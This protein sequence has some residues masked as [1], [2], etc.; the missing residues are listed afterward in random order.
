MLRLWCVLSLTLLCAELA[1]PQV[2][3]RSPSPGSTVLRVRVTDSSGT[4]IAGA[5]VSVVHGLNVVVAKGTTDSAGL[6][7]LAMTSDSAAYQVVVRKIGYLRADRFVPAS[8]RDTVSLDLVLA[9]NIQSLEAVRVA[10]T[11]SAAQKAYHIDAEEIAQ[12]DQLLRTAVDVI[13]KLRP[14]MIWGRAGPPTPHGNGRVC[15]RLSSVFVNGR[16][17]VDAPAEAW[18]QAESR[19]PRRAGL[20]TFKVIGLPAAILTT[21][22]PEHIAEITYN[23]CFEQNASVNQGA[24]AVFIVLKPGVAYIEGEGS[25]VVDLATRKPL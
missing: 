19:I 22:K 2:T 11:E 5:D 13:E 10:A 21:I 4:R 8:H 18:V 17:I 6:R 12:S 16:R 23:D 14:D 1:H 25:V 7:L 24:N 15:N 9:R 3:V 20:A